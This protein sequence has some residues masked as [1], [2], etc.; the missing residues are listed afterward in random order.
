MPLTS[1]SQS[2]VQPED[3]VKVKVKVKEILLIFRKKQNSK[4]AP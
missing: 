3:K 4:L 1:V 2:F